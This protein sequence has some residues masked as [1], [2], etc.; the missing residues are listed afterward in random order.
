[1]LAAPGRALAQQV[2]QRLVELTQ[3]QLLAVPELRVVP[4]SAL[5]GAA[6]LAQIRVDNY[7]PCVVL[8]D[9][10]VMYFHIT[11]MGG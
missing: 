10:K 8:F 3:A 11:P 4:Q 6:L 2:V 1:V 5:L 7:F 9:C